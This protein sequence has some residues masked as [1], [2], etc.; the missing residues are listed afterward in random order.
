MERA[1]VPTDK[2]RLL[3]S[4]TCVLNHGCLISSSTFCLPVVGSLHRVSIWSRTAA[5]T[6]EEGVGRGGEAS[7]HL[8]Q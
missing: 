1:Y 4:G 3:V 8:W 6:L 5:T 7:L 2:K